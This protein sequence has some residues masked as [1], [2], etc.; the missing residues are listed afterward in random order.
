M[1]NECLEYFVT[2]VFKSG[3]KETHGRDLDSKN[4]DTLSFEVNGCVYE[5]RAN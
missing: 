2:N 4:T 5:S 3:S 1:S